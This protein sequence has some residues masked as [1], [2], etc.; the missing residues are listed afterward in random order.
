MSV[1]TP[2]FVSLSPISA[3]LIPVPN[4]CRADSFLFLF[5][6]VCLF[7][8]FVVLSCVDL[9]LCRADSGQCG[10]DSGLCS[11]DSSRPLSFTVVL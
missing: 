5:C 1:L 11:A 4:L 3:V 7:V 10:A 8:L 2:V 6:F 9:I